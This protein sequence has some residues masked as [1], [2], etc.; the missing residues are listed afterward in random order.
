MLL[1]FRLGIRSSLSS[2]FA[3][4]INAGISLMFNSHSSS[5]FAHNEV[6][7]STT[8]CIYL[9]VRGDPF[10][11]DIMAAGEVVQHVIFHLSLLFG[12]C[13]DVVIVIA[14]KVNSRPA[15]NV[16]EDPP[17]KKP[18]ISNIPIQNQII[19]IILYPG[20]ER[21]LSCSMMLLS[22]FFPLVLCTCFLFFTHV[23]T[24]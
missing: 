13:I 3:G 17:D 18:V 12:R 4:P 10:S 20:L 21:F 2:A 24:R 16:D 23:S 14:Q 8:Q 1:V 6:F 7:N 19:S 5:S 11:I 9:F 15:P 22:C